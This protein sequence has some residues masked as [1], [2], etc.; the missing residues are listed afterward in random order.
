MI[1]ESVVYVN[2]GFTLTRSFLVNRQFVSNFVDIL[3][4]PYLVERVWLL[5]KSTGL[6]ILSTALL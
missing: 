1:Y 4:V 6:S 5:I 3:D 2:S